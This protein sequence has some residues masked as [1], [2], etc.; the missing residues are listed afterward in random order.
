MLF[1][2]PVL[3][4]VRFIEVCFSNDVS[5]MWVFTFIAKVFSS[6]LSSCHFYYRF[7]WYI[8]NLF[9]ILSIYVFL[10]FL[11]SLSFS[12]S[13]DYLKCRVTKKEGEKELTSAGSVSK[14]QKQ[15]EWHLALLEK[16]GWLLWSSD[17]TLLG[18]LY[19]SE[20]PGTGRQT[21]DWVLLSSLISLFQCT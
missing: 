20:I 18:Q 4:G 13:E 5:F 10:V 6:L 21:W 12:L 17:M 7:W 9:C 14:W 16:S 2:F 8:C 15:Q 19:C 11:L 1:I 3:S